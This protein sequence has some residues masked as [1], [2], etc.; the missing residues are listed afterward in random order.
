M[1]E[2]FFEA[3]EQ[4]ARKYVTDTIDQGGTGSNFIYASDGEYTVYYTVAVVKDAAAKQN[5]QQNK[6]KLP[7]TPGDEK[8]IAEIY[9]QD[10]ERTFITDDERAIL[11]I[12]ER[13]QAEKVWAVINTLPCYHRPKNALA[14][15]FFEIYRK[16]ERKEYLA[17]HDIETLKMFLWQWK[18]I[19]DFGEKSYD[20]VMR[21]RTEG[22]FKNDLGYTD[23]CDGEYDL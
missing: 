18:D 3:I 12:L 13:P 16:K 15:H 17:I 6:P 9:G 23:L 4:K 8:Q 5:A 14:R 10:D 2:E 19:R 21:L 20:F 7:Y 11:N 22:S 1:K